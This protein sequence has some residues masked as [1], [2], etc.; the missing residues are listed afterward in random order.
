HAAARDVGLHAEHERAAL[1]VVA[2][3]AAAEPPAAVVADGGAERG[4][5]EV[6]PAIADVDADI[7]TRP[8]IERQRG[9]RRFVLEAAAGWRPAEV[10]GDRR[11]GEQDASEAE[12]QRA[13]RPHDGLLFLAPAHAKRTAETRGASAAPYGITRRA[14]FPIR[15]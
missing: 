10:G 6:R 11:Q 8:G 12:Q 5:V 7:E 1:P 3:L 2:D 14:R 4:P 9:C 15:S 13:Q